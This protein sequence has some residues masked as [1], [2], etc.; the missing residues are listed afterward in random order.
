MIKTLKEF[1]DSG[2]L[3][4]YVMGDASEEE[5]KEVEKMAGTYTAIRDAINE[6]ELALEQYTSVH[7]I[8]PDLTIKPF[9]MAS[10]DYS[11]RLKDG[12]IP[13][14][15]PVLNSSSTI[16]DYTEWIT[17]PDMILP[18]DFKDF[19]AKIIGYSPEMITAIAWIQ[20]GAPHETHDKQY[21]KFLI[22]E[23]TCIIT[24]ENEAHHLDA[25]D[26]L[27]IPLHKDHV[28]KIT[29][30]IPCKIILQRIAA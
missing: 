28:V 20:Y 1:I 24:I 11:E 5:S 7:A 9:V 16:E 21:E 3:E 29:S 27:S 17:R 8:A 13:T 30:D 22:L 12:E 4:Q 19:F 26:F 25:G 18:A 10:I 15:P 2:I 23:G 6:I 14:F